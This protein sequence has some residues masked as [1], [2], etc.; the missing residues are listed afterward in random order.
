MTAV[1]GDVAW[2]S[3][4][5][6][7]LLHSPSIEIRRT[8]SCRENNA[9]SQIITLRGSLRK[10]TQVERIEALDTV[11][12]CASKTGVECFNL[13][14]KRKVHVMIHQ[15]SQ[16]MDQF[17]NFALAGMDSFSQQLLPA[18]ESLPSFEVKRSTIGQ[19]QESPVGPPKVSSHRQQMPSPMLLA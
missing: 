4:E 3:W 6:L 9:F 16:L 12:I 17:K 11:K 5:Y 18:M 2:P 1:C 8:N 19:M 14:Y 10:T 15:T 13:R 7:Y